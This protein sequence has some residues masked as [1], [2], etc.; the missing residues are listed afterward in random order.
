MTHDEKARIER[1][2][3]RTARCAYDCSGLHHLPKITW[4]EYSASV[5]FPGSLC[6]FDDSRLTALVIG[7]HDERVRVEVSQGGPGAVKVTL[8]PRPGRDGKQS[9]R[10]PTIEAAIDT[11]RGKV[12]A[13]EVPA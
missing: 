2:L 3:G 5:N 12:H 13:R 4:S 10:H 9:E 6:T 11:Y 7:A 8:W 1:V